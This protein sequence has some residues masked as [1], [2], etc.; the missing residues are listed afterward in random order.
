MVIGVKKVLRWSLI[1][2]KYRNGHRFL[3]SVAVVIEIYVC[4]AHLK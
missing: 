4:A 1:L 2:K 3:K